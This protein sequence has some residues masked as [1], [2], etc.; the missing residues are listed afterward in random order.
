MYA[1]Y[2][3]SP[4][5][6]LYHAAQGWIA[7]DIPL[8]HCLDVIGRFLRRHASSCYSGS[9]DWNFAWL[10]SL[11]QTTWHK[12]SFAMPPRSSPK[13]TCRR[14]W[15]DEYAEELNHHRADLRTPLAALRPDRN[16]KPDSFDPRPLSLREKAAGAVS[17]AR[18]TKSAQQVPKPHRSAFRLSGQIPASGPKKIDLAV[19]WLRAE[20]ASG[21]RTAVEVEANAVC[22]GISRRTYDRARKRLGV[23]SRRIGFGRCAMY[24]IALPVVDGTPNE[25]R[26][27]RA[28]HERAGEVSERVTATKERDMVRNTAR[29]T[30]ASLAAALSAH[31]VKKKRS[32]QRH[33]RGE[34]EKVLAKI[35][36]SGKEASNPQDV[37][38]TIDQIMARASLRK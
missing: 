32:A 30:D 14:D 12:R 13:D 10:N 25:G 33:T 16:S 8:W 1:K 19:A 35:L 28:F 2:R 18:D 11:I 31:G 29:D 7:Q 4:P 9:G 6:G 20:L 27:R 23:T 5:F 22:A 38:Q 17:S 21:G 24:I 36:V 34:V 26:T 3:M 37:L 15:S